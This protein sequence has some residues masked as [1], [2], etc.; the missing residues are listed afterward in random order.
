MLNWERHPRL[1]KN[2]VKRLLCFE[3]LSSTDAAPPLQGRGFCP[4]VFCDITDQIDQKIDI[5]NLYVTEMQGELKPR[6]DSAI[7][8]LARVRGAT[9]SV[10]YGEAF[11]LIREIS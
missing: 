1:P 5:M 4:N 6:S 9:I 10:M 3:C 7:R 11:M 8:A 2:G